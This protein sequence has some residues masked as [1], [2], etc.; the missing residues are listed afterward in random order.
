MFTR[1]P[2]SLAVVSKDRGAALSGNQGPC[3][4]GVSGRYFTH[5]EG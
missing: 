3:R 4:V 2:A 1:R 5:P